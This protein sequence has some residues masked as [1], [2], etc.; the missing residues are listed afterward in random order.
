MQTYGNEVGSTSLLGS[1]PRTSDPV[2]RYQTLTA[3]KEN[4]QCH[5]LSFLGVGTVL[6]GFDG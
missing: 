5:C 1:V 4:P 2:K 3:R 6:S